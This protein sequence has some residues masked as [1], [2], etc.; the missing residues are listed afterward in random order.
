MQ[1]TEQQLTNAT[2]SALFG[3][4]AMITG[5]ATGIGASVAENLLLQ[6]V[7][8]TIAGR[9][10]SKLQETQKSLSHLGQIHYVVVDVTQEESVQQGFAHA[11][12]QQGAIDILINNAGQAVSTS[13]HNTDAKL[14][15][16]IMDVNLT[17]TFHC[18]KSVM[19][20]MLASGWGR[21]VNVSSITGV[22]GYAYVAAYSASK[23]GVI[24]LTRSLAV[25]FANKGVTVNAVCP[26]FTDTDMVKGAVETMVKKWGAT[27]EQALSNLVAANPQKKLIDPKEVSDTIV[28]L[29]MPHSSSINGQSIAI[30]GGEIM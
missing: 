30:A 11:A 3:K 9:T 19:P 13:F 12:E 5:G 21:I 23:H 14:W 4:H 25:E 29:C 17:G 18:S 2:T 6:G 26:G 1:N 20:A 7:K 8:V 16:E 24:G 15:Q 10:E 22:K 28:W 27:P